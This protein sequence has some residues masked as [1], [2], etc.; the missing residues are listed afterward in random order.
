[1]NGTL[2]G[3]A[4]TG[5]AE[6]MNELAR[7]AGIPRTTEEAMEMYPEA[8]TE[9]ALMPPALRRARQEQEQKEDDMNPKDVWLKCREGLYEPPM[10]VDVNLAMIERAMTDL[11]PAELDA[12][13]KAVNERAR[14]L[15]DCDA[16]FDD[17][18]KPSEGGV[19]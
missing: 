12:V 1:M 17:E 16:E 15:R 14:V 3:Y 4:A 7:L 6:G 11:K 2:L 18:T 19:E 5:V 10:R 8:Y 9:E 13:V